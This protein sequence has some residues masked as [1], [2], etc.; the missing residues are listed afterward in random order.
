VQTLEAE[1][2]MQIV[3][4]TEVRRIDLT[5]AGL[6]LKDVIEKEC[7]VMGSIDFSLAGS[8]ATLNQVILIFQKRRES[9]IGG[10]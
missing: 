7:K 10:P 3:I 2:T 6:N 1:K 9:A 8:F 5:A 4:D